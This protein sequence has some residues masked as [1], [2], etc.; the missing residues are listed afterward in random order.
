MGAHRTNYRICLVRNARANPSIREFCSNEESKGWFND[1]GKQLTIAEKVGAVVSVVDRP[2][3]PFHLPP[4][5]APS[6]RSRVAG[7]RSR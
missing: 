5:L 7:E 1:S 3:M 2:E 4:S 6:H